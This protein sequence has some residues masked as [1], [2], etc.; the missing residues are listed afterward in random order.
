MLSLFPLLHRALTLTP[1]TG[2]RQAELRNFCSFVSLVPCQEK[3]KK[4][5]RSYKNRCANRN[6]H[7]RQE[8]T[9]IQRDRRTESCASIQIQCCNC[10][11]TWLDVFF[12]GGKVGGLHRPLFA[13]V[14]LDCK[15]LPLSKSGIFVVMSYYWF[16]TI[17]RGVLL[18]SGN[19]AKKQ[20]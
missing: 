2:S 3:R 7:H 19:L 11:S 4:H 14:P 6:T 15:S 5:T 1:K 12:W 20:Y 18:S 13:I 9:L 16:L 10:R 17:F 8:R